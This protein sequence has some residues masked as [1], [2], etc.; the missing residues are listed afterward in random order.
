MEFHSGRESTATINGTELPTTGWSVDPTSEIVTFRNSKTDR[1]SLKEATYHDLS[2]SI[3]IDFD[4]DENP[5]VA[6]I[7]LAD[8]AE[9]TDVKLYTNGVGS[10]FYDLPSIIIVGTPTS[11]ET[12]GKL[13]VTINFTNN[14]EYGTPGNPVTP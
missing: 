5:F 3:T 9:L 11:V 12:E 13:S 7:G 1:Y 6:P 10:L 2:G 8:G 4:H 14:G